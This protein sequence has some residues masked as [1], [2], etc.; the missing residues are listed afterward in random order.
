MKRVIILILLL[1]L[2]IQTG[3]W[4]QEEIDELGFVMAVA[5]DPEKGENNDDTGGSHKRR[6][7]STF[8]VA[9]PGAMAEDEE[10]TGEKAFFNVTTSGLA[11]FRTV[12]NISKR[13]SRRLFFEHLKV[14]VISDELVTEGI[15]AHLL[16]LYARD[17]EMRRNIMVLI[18]EGPACDV[19]ADKL[20]LEDNPAIS[21]DM[22][23]ENNEHPGLAFQMLLPKDLG[24]VTT[25]MMGDH[26][27][28]LPRIIKGKGGDLKMGGAAVFLG[29]T[30]EMLGWLGDGDISGYNWISE[31][32]AGGIL[33]VPF[34]EEELF[35]YEADGV[36]SQVEFE[37]KND[38]NHFT[39]EIRSEGMFGESW[40]HEQEELDEEMIKKLEEA[41]D[42]EIERQV[43][44]II[45]KMQTEYYADV[46][47]FW[48]EVKIQDYSYWKEVEENW[49]GEGGQFAKA[50][51][52]VN[53]EVEIR[54][55]MLIESME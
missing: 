5:I 22:M 49:D 3:C 25:L 16:D 26:S 53:A 19:L 41:I 46:F 2:C 50:N 52:T 37:R 39:V 31:D 36:H 42:E 35:I 11:N 28:L 20:P 48:R 55:Y 45:E 34:E 15:L 23:R 51:I 24:D 27:F 38:E 21:M 32:V 18:S 29:G 12:R 30:K 7:S 14:I 10:T 44:N 8:Q 54:N 6:F 4:D 1:C 33:E 13:R 47:E 17:H 43:N 40:I 9:V